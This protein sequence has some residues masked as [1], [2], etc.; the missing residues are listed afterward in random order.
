MTGIEYIGGGNDAPTPGARDDLV[1]VG[2]DDQIF[3]QVVCLKALRI[4][5][6][7]SDATTGAYTIFADHPGEHTL[8]AYP[9]AGENLP[10]LV[11]RGVIPI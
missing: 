3:E 9:V 4:G 2:D 1:R 6:A 10:A 5:G 8:V 11:H 7:I